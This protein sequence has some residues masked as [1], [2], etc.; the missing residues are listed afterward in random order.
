MLYLGGTKVSDAGLAHFEDCKNFLILDLTNTRVSD[1][2][3]EQL[4]D[5]SKLGSVGVAGTKVTEAGVKKFSAALPGCKIQWDGSMIEPRTGWHGWSADAPPPAIAPFD[6][7][8]AKQ[9]QEAWAKY[10]GVPVEYT[11]SLGMRFRLIPPRRVLD[12]QHSGG[13]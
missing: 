12:G 5:H 1:A 2:G 7:E 10:L 9:H 13:D 8:Q 11:N 6:A 3:L 4:A